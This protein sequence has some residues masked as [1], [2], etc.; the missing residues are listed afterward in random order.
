MSVIPL[1]RQGTIEEV[2]NLI[3]QFPEFDQPHP[4]SEYKKRF[5]GGIPHLILIACIE[6]KPVA[7]KV[8]YQREVD[9]SFYSWMG[10]VHPEYRRL[11]LARQLAE[12]QEVWAQSKGYRLIRFKTRNRHQK[13][14]LFAIGRGFRIC[15]YEPLPD[16]GESRIWLEKVL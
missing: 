14:L 15:G 13:M 3:D 9:G 6:D 8:G 10:G 11:G 16:P 1:I 4:A 2:V 7:C 12:A 5:V